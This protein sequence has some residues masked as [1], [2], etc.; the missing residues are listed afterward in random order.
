MAVVVAADCYRDRSVLVTGATGFIGS[1]LIGALQGQEARIRAL[2]R[3]GRAMLPDW[4]TVEAATGDLAD[5]VSLG[6]ACAEMETVFHLAGFAHADAGD[7]PEFAAQHW[8]VNAEGTFRLLDAATAVGV[9]Q[10][11][12]LSSVKAAGDPG[13]YCVDERWDAPPETPYGRAKRAAE[14]RVLAVGRAT[15]MQVVNLRPALVYGPGMKGNLLK[16]IKAARCGWLPSL[17]DTGSRRSLVCVDDVVQALL[18]AGVHPAAAGQTYLLTDGQPHS[19]RE[20]YRLIRRTLGRPDPRW[21]MPAPVLYGAAGLA[22]GLSWLVGRRDRRFSD[23]L[24]KLLGWACYDSAKI[25][26]ELGYCPIWTLE[27][28]LPELTIVGWRK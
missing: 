21:T 27:Q 6:R 11:I 16:L 1:R 24:D 26:K 7:T 8:A 23:A 13:P 19:G 14:Q 4:R 18:L 28:A 3:P 5:P 25:S 20:L 15:G 17:P 22:D 9:K 2:I 12:F 10:F